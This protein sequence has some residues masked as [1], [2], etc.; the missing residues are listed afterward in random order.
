MLGNTP[1]VTQ[2]PSDSMKPDPEHKCSP[3]GCAAQMLLHPA[4]PWKSPRLKARQERTTG[5]PCCE[6]GTEVKIKNGKPHLK[7]TQNKLS[8]L[9][10]LLALARQLLRCSVPVGAGMY[11]TSASSSVPH[12]VG[13][14]EPCSKDTVRS[15]SNP[16][17]QTSYL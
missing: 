11:S 2:L 15:A 5:S 16:T 12:R 1:K 8:K 10:M 17:C 4:E 13:P 7:Q 14:G 9:K 6:G 3:L